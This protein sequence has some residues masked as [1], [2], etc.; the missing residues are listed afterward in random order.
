[1]A[2][3][4]VVVSVRTP[5]AVEPARLERATREEV[6]PSAGRASSG[7]GKKVFPSAEQSR[8][9]GAR[10]ADRSPVVPTQSA[11]PST[12]PGLA[13]RILLLVQNGSYTSANT[14]A[15]ALRAQGQGARTQVAF[16]EIAAMFRDQRLTK[17]NDV[18]RRGPRAC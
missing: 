16:A 11:R 9:E 17:I 7:P 15:Q 14:I 2:A 13:E 1:V 3:E 8:E 10:I 5:P 18:I 4:R 6:L 12:A